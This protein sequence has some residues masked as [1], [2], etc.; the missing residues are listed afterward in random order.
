MLCCGRR[1]TAALL[2]PLSCGEDEGS[3]DLD[4]Q[5]DQTLLVVCAANVCRSPLAAFQLQR[6]LSG[7]AEFDQVVVESAGVTARTGSEIC[8][9][10]R[11]LERGTGFAAFAD[12]HRSRPITEAIID[13]ASLILTASTAERSAIATL[14]PAAR[15]RTFTLREAAAL[16]VV[17]GFADEDGIELEGVL[18]RFA[19][20]IHGRRGFVAPSRRP[21][22]LRRFGRTAAPTDPFDIADGHL[23]GSAAHD[24][25]I[26]QVGEVAGLLAD[27]LPRTAPRDV[28]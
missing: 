18:D 6:R 9:R 28:A 13:H 12:A 1:G 21:K 5:R 4:E 20:V 7:L 3:G 26:A 8:E 17:P 14:A 25:T 23:S 24:R 27:A 10:V 11:R 19:A 22:G 15:S 16:A 2:V